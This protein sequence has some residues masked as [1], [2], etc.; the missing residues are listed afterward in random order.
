M[1]QFIKLCSKEVVEVHRSVRRRSF[2]ISLAI[3]SQ[4]VVRLS[5][6]GVGRTFT[7]VDPRI[8]LRLEGLVNWE[9]Q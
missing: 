3:G 8:V 4:A 5:D 2:H 6:L 9:I 1:R 7:T